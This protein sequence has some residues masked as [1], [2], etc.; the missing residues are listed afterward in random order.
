MVKHIALAFIA[1]FLITIFPL[2]LSWADELEDIQKQINSLQK[3]LDMSRQATRPLE[4]A[5]NK[6]QKQIKSIQSQ[7]NATSNQ[8]VKEEQ[9][10]KTLE[11]TIITKEKDIHSQQQ[12]LQTQ[13][14]YTYKLARSISPISL[15]FNQGLSHQTLT[16]I[17]FEERLMMSSRNQIQTL[18][19]KLATLKKIKQEVKKRKEILAVKQ[20]RLASL[21]SQLDKQA[22]FFAKE[23]AGA[24]AYQ[25]M[26]SQKIASLTAR[27]KQ[28]LAQKTGLF[29]TSVG[30]VPLS[31]DP[32]ARADYDPGFR[33]AFAVFS[34]GAP[35]FKGMSQYGAFGRAK[36]GQN[37]QDILKAYYGNIRLETISSPST[38]A[39]TVGTLPFEDRYLMGIAEMPTKWADKGGYE[40]LKAQAI[41]ART[42]ALSYVGWRM[43]SRSVKKRICVTQAC[44]VYKSSKANN[45]PDAWRRAV[46]DTKGLIIV[47]NSTNQIISAW[48]SSTSGGYLKSYTT[49]GHSTPAH[50][51]TQCG[52][53]TCWTPEAYEKIA[54]SP[55]FYKGWYKTRSGKSCGRSH[56]WLT[57]SE[58]AD[59]I[60]TALVY[61]NNPSSPPHLSQTDSC[62][63]SVPDTWSTDRIRQE[64]AKYGG[65]VSSIDRIEVAYSTAGYTSKVIFYTNRGRKEFDGAVFKKVFNLRAPGAI[66][67]VSP[68]YNIEKK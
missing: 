25:N 24:K 2:R 1:L 16:V 4:S 58:M 61:T 22:R 3:Q 28:I 51:D 6:L 11:K 21:Q 10:I 40:A 31:G 8:L 59:I 50:W 53:Q 35:H 66:H 23:I 26:L 9:T 12:K 27:Q 43:D 15:I 13:I 20:K 18:S 30:D 48:Y 34:F 37:Y 46:Q 60:N 36:K 42:Y 57:Q 5:L 38:I 49:L 47:S 68:L 39:T 14:H 7:I 19:E 55:W 17:A 44:Q 33:P 41:A 32:N 65:P 63:G 64:A 29:T 67:L 45:T 62:F 54:G 52:N 56:P